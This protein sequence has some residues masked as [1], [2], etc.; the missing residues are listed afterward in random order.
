M[1]QAT[2]I[3][4]PSLLILIGD[5][6]DPEVFSHPCTINAARGLSLTANTNDTNVPD[7]D[8]PEAI[9]WLLREKTSKQGTVTGAGALHAAD[10]DVFFAWLASDSP[11]NVRVVTNIA[12]G[13]GGRTYS[14]LFH[15]TQFD[16]TGDFGQVVQAN[17]TLVSNGAVTQEPNTVIPP[18]AF[19]VSGWS[20]APA[21]AS[22]AV[23]ITTLP[24]A[25]GASI[26]DIEY[27]VNGG[28][29]VSSGGIV[30]FNITSLTNGV[31]YG[32]A[33][34]A[35]NSAGAGPVSDVKFVTPA[36]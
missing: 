26:T 18:S 4:G 21:N 27:R 29:W 31:A 33:V 24:N 11:R 19:A 34:R 8:D 22:A 23:S 12:A 7:C 32:I 9:P 3:R 15:C 30:G 25:G 14:G 2:T 36:S 10:Q 17:I 20:V 13:S 35:V 16:V 1:A 5:G 6:A 28:S